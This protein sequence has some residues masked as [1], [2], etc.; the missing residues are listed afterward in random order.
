M[1]MII[2][3]WTNSA[4]IWKVSWKNPNTDV[5]TTL[6]KKYLHSNSGHK[7]LNCEHSSYSKELHVAKRCHQKETKGQQVPLNKTGKLAPHLS[8]LLTS[9]H[10]L[11]TRK[12]LPW[13][14]KM[15]NHKLSFL[16]NKLCYASELCTKSNETIT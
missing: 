8:Q 9:G 14:G 12:T 10:L 4:K 7:I 2:S 13:L 15:P 11:L 16:Q 3:S 5:K 6:H 1:F